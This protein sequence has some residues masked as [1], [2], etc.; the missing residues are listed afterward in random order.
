[1]ELEVRDNPDESRYEIL[2]DG[3]RIGLAD[4]RREPGRISLVHTEVDPEHQGEGVASR[5]IR[6]ALEDARRRDLDVLPY[7]P[8]VRAFI[9]EHP[10]FLGRV[11]EDVRGRFGLE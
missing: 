4:Y 10:S 11:P 5:L 6:H 2:A 1:M 7:C 9:E 8:F 3:E